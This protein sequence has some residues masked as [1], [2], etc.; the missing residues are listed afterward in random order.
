MGSAKHELEKPVTSR[1]WPCGAISPQGTRVWAL[2]SDTA[3]L[4][5]ERVGRG[6][7]QA[8]GELEASG[9]VGHSSGPQFPPPGHKE[10]Q[11]GGERRSQAWLQKQ[12]LV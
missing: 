12:P 7:V 1:Q 10:A 11:S 6:G 5:A 9:R 8:I 2:L 4:R 3:G